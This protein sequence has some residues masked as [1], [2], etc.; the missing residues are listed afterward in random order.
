M[1]NRLSIMGS[2]KKLDHKTD[3]LTSEGIYQFIIGVIKGKMMQ[4]VNMEDERGV[5][6]I[7][8]ELLVSAFLP[9][10][11]DQRAG[12]FV[13]AVIFFNLV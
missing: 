11:I 10:Q 12:K 13:F 7:R 2:H 9:G 6:Q 4:G 1:Q 5:G 3:E 8:F